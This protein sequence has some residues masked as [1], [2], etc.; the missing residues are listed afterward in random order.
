V[1]TTIQ[2][3]AHPGEEHAVQPAHRGG[4]RS[5]HIRARAR[6][7]LVAVG[8]VAATAAVLAV[9]SSIVGHWG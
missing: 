4:H 7:T 3:S 8:A 1:P 2:A 9:A 6:Q 5:S